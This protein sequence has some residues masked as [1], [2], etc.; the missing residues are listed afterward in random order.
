[1]P[2]IKESGVNETFQRRAL[3][4][5]GPLRQTPLARGFVHGMPADDPLP[6]NAL[7]KT[8]AEQR[9]GTTGH[10]PALP[11]MQPGHFHGDPLDRARRIENVPLSG[12]MRIDGNT[13]R[14]IREHLE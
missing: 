9:E 4:V 5:A 8:R 6:I 3:A 1:M 7:V 12:A 14:G 2:G 13:R 10:R 11:W